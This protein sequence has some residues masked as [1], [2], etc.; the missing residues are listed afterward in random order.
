MAGTA[1]KSIT[2]ATLK[3]KFEATARIW[4]SHGCNFNK[5]NYIHKYKHTHTK[6]HHTH[7]HTHTHIHQT[8]TH[9]N[10]QYYITNL[11]QYG[12]GNPCIKLRRQSG[13]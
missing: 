3:C 7:I 6:I 9:T 5:T 13:C 11:K 1:I 8:H 4:L 10:I 2:F 12:K